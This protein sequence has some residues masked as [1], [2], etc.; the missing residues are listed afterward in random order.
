MINLCAYLSLLSCMGL[1][2]QTKLVQAI[3]RSDLYELS[4]AQR[5][6]LPPGDDHREE[7][8]LHPPFFFYGTNYSD[9]Y[10]SCSLN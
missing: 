2:T 6:A 10:V 3:T 9:I 8:I 7:V 4:S 1:L 5:R